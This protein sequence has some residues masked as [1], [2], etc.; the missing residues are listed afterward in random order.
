MITTTIKTQP[1]K[2]RDIRG[3]K[4]KHPC[5][6]C[7]KAPRAAFNVALKRPYRYSIE[8]WECEVWTYGSTA[9]KALERWN[10]NEYFA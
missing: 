3:M 6:K 5:P 9:L 1:E 10:A 7:K 2:F 8:C 4:A